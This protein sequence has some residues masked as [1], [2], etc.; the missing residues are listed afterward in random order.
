MAE[1]SGPFASDY[2][3]DYD[4]FSTDIY[5][6]SPQL[7]S[8]STS[9]PSFV[10]SFSV[11]STSS[12]SDRDKLRR[13]VVKTR[14]KRFTVRMADGSIKGGF[15]DPDDPFGCQNV[16][17]NANDGEEDPK[18]AK[19]STHTVHKVES[20]D[21]DL[22]S[23]SGVRTPTQKEIEE[24]LAELSEGEQ[25]EL[26][27]Y[28][29]QER[30]PPARKDS[31]EWETRQKLA[32]TT[33][34]STSEADTPL[35]AAPLDPQVPN[36]QQ[37]LDQIEALRGDQSKPQSVLPQYG[38][39]L[40]P[41]AVN[42]LYPQCTAKPEWESV[43][44]SPYYDL[45]RQ[46]I[47]ERRNVLMYEGV[48]PSRTW[49][50]LPAQVTAHLAA[51]GRI[52]Y[53][54]AERYGQP[55]LRPYNVSEARQACGEVLDYPFNLKA[56]QV[57]GLYPWMPLQH[58]IP[59]M[60]DLSGGRDWDFKASEWSPP[61][62]TQENWRL[63]IYAP[64]NIRHNGRT[65][66]A[67]CRHR[68]VGWN[69][70]PW[71]EIC[72]VN[73][74]II[75]CDPPTSL[76]NPEA[77][78]CYI[79]ERMSPRLR[80]KVCKNI[81]SKREELKREGKPLEVKTILLPAYIRHQVHA[82][83]AE[84]EVHRQKDVNNAWREGY[85]GFCRP[86]YALPYYMSAFELQCHFQTGQV[87]SDTITIH[88]TAFL[89]E[90]ER[91]ARL[92]PALCPPLREQPVS[93]RKTS[94]NSS[95]TEKPATPDNPTAPDNSASPPSKMSEEEAEVRRLNEVSPE[96]QRPAP[97]FVKTRR[98]I[99]AKNAIETAVQ[100]STRKKPQV[101]D[102]KPE[103]PP[104]LE[105]ID[106]PE[107]PQV[108]SDVQVVAVEPAPEPGKSPRKRTQTPSSGDI[109][110]R[111]QT[112]RTKKKP[113]PV[114]VKLPQPRQSNRAPGGPASVQQAKRQA[115]KEKEEARMR[116][117]AQARREWLAKALETQK[118]KIE[119]VEQ[120]STGLT[121]DENQDVQQAILSSVTASP[122]RRAFDKANS[123]ITR[124]KTNPKPVA[125]STPAAT[126]K[127]T[128]A[129][130][131]S[132][133]AELGRGE[134]TLLPQRKPATPAQP[135]ET[136][137]QVIRIEPVKQ[138]AAAPKPPAEPQTKKYIA[139]AEPQQSPGTEPSTSARYF[140][141]RWASKSPQC[142]E[143][144]SDPQHQY[145]QYNT[146]IAAARNLS[147]QA[148]DRSQVAAPSNLGQWS[149]KSLLTSCPATFTPSAAV[150]SPINKTLEMYRDSIWE[151][152]FQK[153]EIPFCWE[154]FP[155]SQVTRETSLSL[156]PDATTNYP[157]DANL[158]GLLQAE[159]R[160]L[161]DQNRA[162]IK[163]LESDE[164]FMSAL[165]DRFS[166]LNLQRTPAERAVKPFTDEM[167]VIDA[168]QINLFKRQELLGVNQG[169]LTATR[170]RDIAVRRDLTQDAR[171]M[172]VSKRFDSP[173]KPER[174]KNRTPQAGKPQAE[175]ESKTTTST[176]QP[177]LSSTTLKLLK[178]RLPSWKP[179]DLKTPQ[180]PKANLTPGL[181]T[182]RQAGTGFDD[183][184][185]EN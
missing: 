87:F 184:G 116:A 16:N 85:I 103:K 44:Y 22:V 136:E 1:Y 3:P 135:S 40:N 9:L 110:K 117:N 164:F 53:K 120:L 146:A 43:C 130:R 134:V 4:P 83:R 105:T 68:V 88:T 181:E 57:L 78:D 29:Y 59:M 97:M 42:L 171:R 150:L 74:G 39:P 99:A 37:Q 128:P 167:Q 82:D 72:L 147:S 25:A 18:V 124:S 101:S 106:Q 54:P 27:E 159:V 142:R 113:Q 182:A 176:P 127:P 122:K 36:V 5:Q 61:P 129:R 152:E 144:T 104:R 96:L 174:A 30:E 71:C 133:L 8:P 51:M 165:A 10:E 80:Q 52:K 178:R 81:A 168:L 140:L 20:Q 156:V 66:A 154:D 64:S 48:G 153:G 73:A 180:Q 139:D 143:L 170:R 2:N 79:C 131:I 67:N 86:M 77:S 70:H 89:A 162:M 157:T 23:D 125:T 114:V 138:P 41:G 35:L 34:P 100:S 75:T 46:Y 15:Y 21:S 179:E 172:I 28:Q 31:S 183:T 14:L 69:E 185:S 11:A 163:L 49:F 60:G 58:D 118:R 91:V 12:R 121:D 149:S 151:P 95:V 38:E 24:M 115:E 17:N 166:Q 145:P 90:Y 63:F 47:E 50:Y 111:K 19:S 56:K 112:R 126:P 161:D 13:K 26:L 108:D 119:Q 148:A 137:A 102:T 98:A 62:P 141:T 132:K 158:V 107:Q 155:E 173:L 33:D 94:D 177:Q 76:T 32:E 84:T 6:V 45:L 92:H 160:R 93:V 175:L 169:I 109:P 65:Y 55:S 7:T 123:R